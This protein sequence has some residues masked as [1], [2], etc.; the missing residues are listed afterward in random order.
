MDQ[1][2]RDLEQH[3]GGGPSPLPS[4][5]PERTRDRRTPSASPFP[6]PACS[7]LRMT[8][9]QAFEIFDLDEDATRGD[10][11]RAFRKMAKRSHPDTTRR[12]DTSAFREAR[13]AYDLLLP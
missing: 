2:R 12:K 7:R 1:P 11:K 3:S 8:I 13:E 5:D 9:K 6:L 10:L 4:W